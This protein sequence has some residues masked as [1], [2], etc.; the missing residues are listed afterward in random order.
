MDGL[1][2]LEQARVA[3]LEIRRDGGRLT[4]RGPREAGEIAKLV[5]ANKS[6]VIEDFCVECGKF[7]NR[8]GTDWCVL[9]GSTL[10]RGCYEARWPHGHPY[11]GR[12]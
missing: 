10:H 6:V 8:T 1:N 4:I 3:G 7:V 2:L 5:L 9:N 11:F 12:L